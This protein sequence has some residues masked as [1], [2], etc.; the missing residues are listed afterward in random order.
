MGKATLTIPEIHMKI[1]LPFAL[2]ALSGCTTLEQRAGDYQEAVGLFTRPDKVK[3]CYSRD[4]EDR[5]GFEA[6]CFGSECELP[7]CPQ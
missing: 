3:V 6:R 4:G 7:D 2:L 5:H 1:V